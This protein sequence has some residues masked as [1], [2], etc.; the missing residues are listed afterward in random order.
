MISSKQVE[1]M[2]LSLTLLG[3]LGL[4]VEEDSC[5]L[6]TARVDAICLTYLSLFFVSA[7]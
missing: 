7:K 4:E 2:Q 1:Q 6:V 3:V 5:L